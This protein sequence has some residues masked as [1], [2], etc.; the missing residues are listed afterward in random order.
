MEMMTRVA[1]LS[2]IA[3][4]PAQSIISEVKFKTLN[5][6]SY[7]NTGKVGPLTTLSMAGGAPINIQGSMMGTMAEMN[8]I[9]LEPVWLSGTLL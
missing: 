4:L 8:T 2:A 6:V 1:L 7:Y 5:G 3:L 9:V